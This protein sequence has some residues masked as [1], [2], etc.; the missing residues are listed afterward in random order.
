MDN[1]FEIN[2]TYDFNNLNLSDPILMNNN[3]YFSKITHGKFNKNFYLKLN[4]T[5][6]KNGIVK[7]SNKQ[8]CELNYIINENN[9]VL[10]FFENLEKLCLEKITHNKEKW[11]YNSNN[12]TKNDIEDLINPICKPYKYGKNILIKTFIL[13]NKILIYDEDENKLN[14][15][16]FNINHEFIP[17]IHIN[18]IKFSNR[19]LVLDIVLKQ[20]LLITPN[21]DFDN[22]CLLLNTKNKDKQHNQ[23]QQNI[24]NIQNDE[25][26]EDKEVEEVEELKQVK[27]VEEDKQVKEVE[28]DKEVKEDKEDKEDKEVEEFKEV[29]E[30]EEFK[31]VKEVEEDK[32]VE[33]NKE[34][35]EIKEHKED[36]EVEELKQVEQLKEDK[37]LEEDMNN[38]KAEQITKNMQ[39]NVELEKSK[40]LVNI[41]IIDLEDVDNET[42]NIKS[43]DTIYLEM[44]KTAKKKAKEI[45][46]NAI[47]AFIEA[48]NI[49][50]QYNLDNLVNSDSSEEEEF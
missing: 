30:V 46:K 29:K 47:K 9:N 11:F 14:L 16:D 21:D 42:F 18:G 12:I 22:K 31:E 17:L 23:S 37:M 27:E 33:Q 3:N 35:E 36:K 19:S 7:T 32:E 43:R 15:E 28:E 50:S 40:D 20:I 24:Q 10:E 5:I 34:V 1:I 49:K 44:Y 4:K 13:N 45:R 41:D 39:E 6:S 25:V 2:N 8:Y 26:K 48:K 38:K